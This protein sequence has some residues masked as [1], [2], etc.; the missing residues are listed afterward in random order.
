MTVSYEIVMKSRGEWRKPF[1]DDVNAV[2]TV[3]PEHR[4]MFRAACRFASIQVDGHGLVRRANFDPALD[5]IRMPR[6]EDFA[7]PECWMLVFMHEL[8]HWTGH[9][10][11]LARNF[12]CAPWSS[13]YWI[14]EMTA[15][16][17]AMMMTKIMNAKET[18]ESGRNSKLYL[19]TYL[20]LF[21]R[22]R[23]ALLAYRTALLQSVVATEVLIELFQKHGRERVFVREMDMEM[24]DRLTRQAVDEAERILDGCP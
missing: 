13:D 7:L 12:G 9:R 18:P 6:Y 5:T 8:T 21:E 10:D 15:E 16:L 11:R 22:E 1:L 19:R 4:T 17:G 14:E 24:A 3:P 23:E 2:G 20:K